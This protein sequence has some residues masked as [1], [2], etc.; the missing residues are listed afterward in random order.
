[1]PAIDIQTP[2]RTSATIFRNRQTAPNGVTTEVLLALVEGGFITSTTRDGHLV[3]ERRGEVGPST[4]LEA[5]AICPEALLVGVGAT[6]ISYNGE[7][8]MH[9][10][11]GLLNV[12]DPN[13]VPDSSEWSIAS[14][15]HSDDSV[16]DTEEFEYGDEVL[17][18]LRAP[19]VLDIVPRWV[20]I[21]DC[22]G[23][24]V[25]G[26]EFAAVGLVDPASDGDRLLATRDILDWGFYGES[27]GPCS[28]DGGA[29]LGWCGP[30]LWVFSRWGDIDPEELVV[31]APDP[32]DLAELIADWVDALD[33]ELPFLLDVIGLPG[34]TE[35]E[36][37]KL[38]AAADI[39]GPW[40]GSYLPKEAALDAV[41][42]LCRRWE[43][44]SEAVEGLRN[45]E[46]ERGL[47][48]YGWLRQIAH[49]AYQSGSWNQVHAAMLG[50]I[51]PP[52]PDLAPP[53][54]QERWI[55]TVRAAEAAVAAGLGYAPAIDISEGL[56]EE[57]DR[58]GSTPEPDPELPALI[59]RLAEETST[60]T[61]ERSLAV[62]GCET[63]AGVTAA[64]KAYESLSADHPERE[65][66]YWDAY[67]VV[68]MREQRQVLLAQAQKEQEAAK[69]QQQ[70]VAE[71]DWPISWP[72]RYA[73]LWQRLGG[74]GA[75]AR[76]WAQA[77]WTIREVLLERQLRSAW[78]APVDE[79]VIT[80]DVPVKP[81]GV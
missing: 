31:R 6:Q 75:S 2:Q 76:A 61:R 78:N 55:Q 74:T 36:I 64:W 56:V 17:A 14:Q 54:M 81:D 26:P 3:S 79:R 22:R 51:G 32:D 7:L 73:P 42:I 35:D 37:A 16:V 65:R 33:W 68:L 11:L 12:Q 70:V 52:P 23:F 60:S 1:M 67:Q 21:N 69:R 40:V 80:I 30:R 28:W 48:V 24:I 5:L 57:V 62:L 50:Q 59:Q 34:L 45:H 58:L 77:G 8:D 44:L 46:S 39:E 4:M 10:L 53:T 18:S 19:E 13:K 49:G 38:G 41:E 47:A 43:G 25:R 15:S 27:G 63:G 9:D 66:E 72:S 71:L 29:R 20:T